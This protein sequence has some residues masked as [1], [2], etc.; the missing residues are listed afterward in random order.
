MFSS[1]KLYVRLM[2][3]C[4]FFLTFFSGGKIGVLSNYDSLLRDDKKNI[5]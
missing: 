3:K 5:R 2:D 4:V 1:Y